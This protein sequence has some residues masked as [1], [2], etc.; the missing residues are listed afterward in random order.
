MKRRN[1]L[2]R[3]VLAALALP[4]AIKGFCKSIDDNIVIA[5]SLY[6]TETHI[7]V[8][9]E[10]CQNMVWLSST[11]RDQ[12]RER[13]KWTPPNRIQPSP[14]D[15]IKFNGHT[16]YF[17]YVKRIQLDRVYIHILNAQKFKNNRGDNCVI[18]DLAVKREKYDV[19]C[20]PYN[21]LL[22]DNLVGY[23]GVGRANQIWGKI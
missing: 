9:L 1:F 10:N 2:T 7:W 19:L 3:L 5:K 8:P 15:V 6:M 13:T 22:K 17:A 14:N 4:V 20:L 18:I 11:T 23:Q 12:N 21:S 16:G